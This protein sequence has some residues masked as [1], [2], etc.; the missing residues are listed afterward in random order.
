V[1]LPNSGIRI[2]IS[3]RYWPF[4]GD[5]DDR[6]WIAPDIPVALTIDDLLAGDDPA[7]QAA[8]DAAP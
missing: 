7:L 2:E 1:E 3:S 5:E 8:L 4:G 6:P